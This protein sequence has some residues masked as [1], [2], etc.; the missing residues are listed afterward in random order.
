[1][2]AK[3]FC[4]T[5][6]EMRPKIE[7]RYS[8]KRKRR[9][10]ILLRLRKNGSSIAVNTLKKRRRGGGPCFPDRLSLV[11][12]RL[13]LLMTLNKK[14]FA[15]IQTPVSIGI[16]LFAPRALAVFGK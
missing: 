8:K 9:R 1:M 16:T 6:C 11:K 10:M 7:P 4:K 15:Y 5:L 12:A 2:G 14:R 13:L 3:S